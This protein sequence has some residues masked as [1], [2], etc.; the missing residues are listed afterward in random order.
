MAIWK[1]SRHELQSLM[2]IKAIYK[3]KLCCFMHVNK[4][5]SLMKIAYFKPKRHLF[6]S[7]S[8]KK[9]RKKILNKTICL[10]THF[11]EISLSAIH[12]QSSVLIFHHS[13]ATLMHQ[14]HQAGLF[15]STLLNLIFDLSFS[16]CVCNRYGT[17]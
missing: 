8:I 4:V 9:N 1:H 12:H 17:H 13:S 7:L 11:R 5:T 6:T 10:Q 3:D 14:Y 16:L 15:H 2:K